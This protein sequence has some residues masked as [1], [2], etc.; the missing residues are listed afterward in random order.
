[1]TPRAGWSRAAAR[2]IC[3]GELAMSAPVLAPVPANPGA[4]FDLGQAPESTAVVDL[5]DPDRP[6]ELSYARMRDGTDAFGRGLRRAGFGRGS[7]IGIVSANRVE[8]FEA[9]FGAMKL[10]AIPVPLNIR[11]ATDQLRALVAAHDIDLIMC[12]P[13]Q[14]RRLGGLPNRILTFGSPGW[15]EFRDAGSLGAEALDDDE[16]ILQPF[17]SGS[18]GLPKGILL[19]AGNLRWALGKMLPPGRPRNPALTITVA[20][21]LY[22]KNAM[23][24][25]KGAFL[26]GGRVVMMDRFEPRR[27]AE[28]IGLWR[29]S[30][31]H[32]VPTMMARLLAE[33]G[34]VAR[35]DQSSIQEVHM[36]SAPVSRRLWDEVCAAFPAANLRISYGVT[37]AGPMQ[38]G[39]HP[40]GLPRPPLSVGYPLPDCELRLVGGATEDEGVLCIRN[41]GVMRGYHGDPERT[42]ARFDAEG[43]YVTGDVFRRDADGFYFFVGRD[44]DMF[45]VSGNN[46]YP[47]AVEETLL[48]HPE[49]LAAAVVPVEDAI[50]GQAPH[51]FVVLRSGAAVNEATLRAFCLEHA[52]P[53]QHPRRI[54]FLDELPLAGTGKVD[55]RSLR[56]R[57]ADLAL[58]DAAASQGSEG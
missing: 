27:F 46:L 8:V 3:C 14:A 48:R 51:A 39:E 16:L 52:P 24:G 5:T 29:V 28:A 44:D 22:H 26:N 30:K 19:T 42:A 32:T 1:M 55:V 47:A 36:G 34:L 21:P 54:H 56:N 20:H 17:T 7:R 57:A 10:G 6:V 43:W 53:Y 49:V 41:P 4:I 37:E 11:L 9:F 18:T 40:D 58:D 13:D 23:L 45:V 2:P 50:R 31:V 35:I 15:A 25:S 33:P 38:F 12:D